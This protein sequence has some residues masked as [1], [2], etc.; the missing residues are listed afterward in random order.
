MRLQPT[1]LIRQ[2]QFSAVWALHLD[3]KPIQVDESA[4]NTGQLDEDTKTLITFAYVKISQQENHRWTGFTGEEDAPEPGSA[5]CLG[6][7][8]LF[9]NND[10]I[11]VVFT[12]EDAI[13]LYQELIPA[14][15]AHEEWRQV[16]PFRF[17]GFEGKRLT[18]NMIQQADRW[19]A[20]SDFE[21][22]AQ[23]FWQQERHEIFMRHTQQA[24]GFHQPPKLQRRIS[25]KR[26]PHPVFESRLKSL[27]VG[28]LL[29]AE[30]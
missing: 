13:A 24:S 8:A 4:W 23:T 3:G 17:L 7:K 11:P 29:N 25:A 30:A 14:R 12:A 16:F 26:P 6:E 10:N 15:K 19:K 9:I 27:D 21:R 28:L 1:G 20:S 22:V 2:P 5:S 18:A